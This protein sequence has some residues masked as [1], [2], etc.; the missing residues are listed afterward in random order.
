MLLGE[1]G[2]GV[3]A[4]SKYPIGAQPPATCPIMVAGQGTAAR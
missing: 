2:A 1:T 4:F 3:V